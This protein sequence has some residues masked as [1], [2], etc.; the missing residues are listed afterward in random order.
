MPSERSRARRFFHHP[1]LAGSVLLTVVM[2]TGVVHVFATVQREV[3]LPSRRLLVERFGWELGCHN[4]AAD[5]WFERTI[6]WLEGTSDAYE[7]GI[8]AGTAYRTHPPEATVETGKPSVDAGLGSDTPHPMPSGQSW[9]NVGITHVTALYDPVTSPHLLASLATCDAVLTENGAYFDTVQTTARSHGKPAGHLPDDRRRA[10]TY[11]WP[12]IVGILTLV[13]MVGLGLVLVHLPAWSLRTRWWPAVGR[14][15]CRLA[16]W[17]GPQHALAAG[18]WLWNR[19]TKPFAA[20]SACLT[21][22]WPWL[23][24]P[25]KPRNPPLS[26]AEHLTLGVLMFSL[27]AGLCLVLLLAVNCYPIMRTTPHASP[28]DPPV[29]IRDRMDRLTKRVIGSF[30]DNCLLDSRDMYD[31][32]HGYL[33]DHPGCRHLLVISG[34]THAQHFEGFERSDP[35]RHR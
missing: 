4:P 12:C 32:L 1:M 29:G 3:V 31:A 24:R 33:A 27:F 2:A 26:A 7:R 10:S 25:S 23:S 21:R 16:S 6:C 34:E 5:T 11:T 17:P 15:A 35:Y 13:M 20:A 19:S 30:D 22:R 18:T 8:I 9:R 28:P 14:L